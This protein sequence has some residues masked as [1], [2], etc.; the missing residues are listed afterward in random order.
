MCRGS[1]PYRRGGSSPR[2]DHHSF[3]GGFQRERFHRGPHGPGGPSTPERGPHG[4][5]GPSTPERGPHGPGGPPTP[6]RDFQSGWGRHRSLSSQE[7][8]DRPVLLKPKSLEEEKEEWESISD[9]DDNLG[10]DFDGNLQSPTAENDSGSG[11]SVSHHDSFTSQ[12]TSVKSQ[13]QEAQDKVAPRSTSDCMDE[14]KDSHKQDLAISDTPP[15]PVPDKPHP[16]EIREFPRPGQSPPEPR[17]RSHSRSLSPESHRLSMPYSPARPRTPPEQVRPMSPPMGEPISSPESGEVGDFESPSEKV[18]GRSAASRS[19]TP[20]SHDEE[21][22]HSPQ[23]PLSP[24]ELQEHSESS[25]LA[26]LMTSREPLH[27]QLPSPPAPREPRRQSASHMER[28]IRGGRGGSR[29][30]RRHPAI[31]PIPERETRASMAARHAAAMP[32][33]R[34]SRRRSE[35]EGRPPAKR[36]RR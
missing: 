1:R 24:A 14:V 6:E 31:Q 15:V 13:P 22:S 10:D 25:G 19:L 2:G 34:S 11:A 8:E 16:T 30:A 35:D 21:P 3:R 33:T 36:L 7:D 23:A 20:P 9:E 29:D 27:Q 4:P 32:M 28:S 5:G 26:S 17:K 18:T 12:G